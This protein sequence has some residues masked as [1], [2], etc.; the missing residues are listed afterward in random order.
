M[1][2]PL[3]IQ[4]LR[5]DFGTGRVSKLNSRNFAALAAATQLTA[6]TGLTMLNLGPDFL[7]DAGLRQAAA[8]PLFARLRRLEL[9]ADGNAGHQSPRAPEPFLAGL[10]LPLLEGLSLSG[11][12]RRVRGAFARARLP[13]LRRLAV[14]GGSE[15]LVDMLQEL[16]H[17]QAAPAL[18][19]IAF[20]DVHDNGVVSVAVLQSHTP[21]S[22]RALTIPGNEITVSVLASFSFITQLTR[23]DLC[24]TMLMPMD[25]RA[26]AA[27]AGAPLSSLRVLVLRQPLS[28]GAARA[29]AHAPWLASLSC[30]VLND[31]G[32]KVHYTPEVPWPATLEAL[33]ASPAFCALEAAGRVRLEAHCPCVE[34]L[35]EQPVYNV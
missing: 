21:P 28:V 20:G 8:S 29:L 16:S 12:H 1:H 14:C 32:I 24:R 26:C 11:W 19:Y 35:C 4:D 22:L 6:L 30:L 5:A 17:D 10:T 31:C 34:G 33:R 7:G 15:S 3:P 2:S 25:A 23:I 13:A 18:E 9:E 27:L